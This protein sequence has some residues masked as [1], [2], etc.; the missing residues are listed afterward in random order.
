MPSATA[1][2]Q[3]A[4]AQP[5]LA[6][7]GAGGHPPIVAVLGPDAT[8]IDT[9]RACLG[10]DVS[11]DRDRGRLGSAPT[12]PLHRCCEATSRRTIDLATEGP[13]PISP[14]ARA[15][16]RLGRSTHAAQAQ[17]RFAGRPA[18]AGPQHRTGDRASRAHGA[19]AVLALEAQ[20]RGGDRRP[21]AA[22]PGGQRRPARPATTTRS[23]GPSPRRR[24]TSS[25][26]TRRRSAAWTRPSSSR[27]TTAGS[28]IPRPRRRSRVR[29]RR[30]ASSTASSWRPARSS[31]AG[32]SPRIERLASVD[33]RYSSDPAEIKKADGEALIEA[34]ETAEPE[35]QVEARGVLIDLATEQPPARRRADRR[36]DRDRPA[37][38]AVP[39]RGGDGRDA[40]RR[41]G[42]RRVG[43]DPAR[44]RCRRRSAC[45]AS[46]R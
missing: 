28:P 12:R 46:R 18:G 5:R 2:Q 34:G 27:S 15:A 22:G 41:A 16:V 39:L 43:P 37:H 35:V 42:R 7:H 33:V 21:G 19:H 25:R 36:A 6:L 9:T 45:P 11:C 8:R 20:P 13:S 26:P 32:R 29:S 30:S 24:S 4:A 31:R 17:Q 38:P 23:R 44:P 14:S 40:H 10:A 1:T 3:L